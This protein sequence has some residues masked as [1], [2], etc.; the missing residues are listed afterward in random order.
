MATQ[1]KNTGTKRAQSG[2]KATTKT[3][4][5]TGDTTK[6]SGDILIQAVDFYLDLIEQSAPKMKQAADD[7]YEIGVGA[8]K[9]VVKAEKSILDG[10][11]IESGLISKSEEIF[12]KT[13]DE[14]TAAQK[15]ISQIS[16]N[17]VVGSVKLVRDELKG[18]QK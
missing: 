17:T 15:R 10:I 4:T 11:G 1:K 5:K 14:M 7:L 9:T 6:T 2:A 16:S 8:A 13:A 3:Q 12:N 18:Q